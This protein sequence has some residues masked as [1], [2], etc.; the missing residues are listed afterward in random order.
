MVIGLGA[1]FASAMT[2]L[3]HIH[4]IGAA[5]VVT[6]VLG[7]AHLALAMVIVTIAQHEAPE[8]LRGRVMGAVQVAWIGFLPFTSQVYGW[9]ADV[10]SIR[11]VF[12][13]TGLVCL[14]FCLGL[15]RWRG[16]I[17]MKAAAVT[18]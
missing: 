9:L 14:A 8:H 6:G 7:G 11:T 2:V 17:R 16:D 13:V 12:T 1:T 15:T 10:F 3:G 5:L 4:A 18:S